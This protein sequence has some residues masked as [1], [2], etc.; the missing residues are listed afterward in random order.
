MKKKHLLI[1]CLLVITLLF[2]G[3]NEE[4]ADQTDP[5]IPFAENESLSYVKWEYDNWHDD[6]E[7]RDND[8][9]WQDLNNLSSTAEEEGDIGTI[10]EG[11]QLLNDYG[12]YSAFLELLIEK[13]NK[14]LNLVGVYYEPTE[15]VNTCEGSFDETFFETYNLLIVD[16]CAA[17]SVRLQTRLGKM[18]T[19]DNTA[20]VTLEVEWVPATTASCPGHIYFIPIPKECVNADVNYIDQDWD[21]PNA[22][23]PWTEPLPPVC[24]SG[25]AGGFEWTLENNVLTITGEGVLTDLFSEDWRYIAYDATTLKLDPRI[26]AIGDDTFSELYGLNCELN[27]HEGLTSVGA[28]AFSTYGL[29]LTSL[30]S[31]LTDIGAEAFTNCTLPETFVIPAAV[32]TIGDGAFSENT[33]MKELRI[34]GNPSFGSYVFSDSSDLKTVTLPESLTQLGS[35]LFSGCRNLTQIQL[36]SEITVIPQGCFTN[37]S[38]LTELSLPSTVTVIDT[39]AFSGCTSLKELRLPDTVTAI[40]SGA[41]SGC[42]GLTEVSLPDNLLEIGQEAFEGCTGLTQIT[43]PASVTTI[44]ERPFYLCTALTEIQVDPNNPAYASDDQG[45]LYTKE[46][47]RLIQ[48]PPGR[49][50]TFEIPDSVPHIYEWTFRGCQFREI[51]LPETMKIIDWQA[52]ADCTKLETLI[53][54]DS[55]TDLTHEMLINCTALKTVRLPA[56]IQRVYG[57]MFENCT[58]LTELHLPKTITIIG[59]FAFRNCTSLTDIYF[60]GTEEEWNAISIARNPELEEQITVHFEVPYE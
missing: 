59:G 17:G 33:G 9:Y 27:L 16:Y 7:N 18:T 25:S 14:C 28:N 4:S 13:K 10:L 34:E 52:F 46:M 39:A 42:T 44:E 22:T 21:E 26:T 6:N 58:S 29:T 37:C 38:S 11:H 43:I 50:G 53:I 45:A 1:I 5:T 3:C 55:A 2:A 51:L 47:T 60:E 40:G 32:Q 36:P 8:A 56:G 20:T 12:E 15:L 31:T 24:E 48:P 41:F 19:K 23:Y 49:Q 54:P 35:N 30:P 57:S